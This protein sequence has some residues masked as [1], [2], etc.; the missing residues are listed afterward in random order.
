MNRG[1][2]SCE[3]PARRS[4]APENTLQR[5]ISGC[6]FFLLFYLY[7]WLVIDPRLLHHSLGL[8][9]SYHCVSYTTE[10]SFFWEC[11]SRPGGVV[12]YGA[13]FLWQFFCYGWMGALIVTA[14]AWTTSLAVDVLT[15]LADRPRGLVVRFVPAVLLAVICGHYEQ[16][17]KTVLSLLVA[18][19]CFAAYLRWSSRGGGG[20]SVALLVLTC[21]VA[22]LLAGSGGLLFPCLAA[23]FEFIHR[24]R[25]LVGLVALLCVAGV[26]LTVGAAV[27]RI[28]FGEQFWSCLLSDEQTGRPSWL[29]TG[30]YLFFLAAFV[31]ATW[32]RHWQ[33]GRASTRERR[34]KSESTMPWRMRMP[35]FLQVGESGFA[36]RLAVVCLTAGAIAWSTLDRSGRLVLQLD[37]YCQHGKWTEALD[38]AARLPTGRVRAYAHRNVLLALCRT[39]RLLDEMFHYPQVT[40]DPYYRLVVEGGNLLFYTQDSRIFL[41]LGQVNLAEKCCLE[42]MVLSGERPSILKQLAVINI[43]KDR[44]ETAKVFLNKLR[45]TLLHRKEAEAMLNRLEQD[46]RMDDDPTVGRLRLFMARKDLASIKVNWEELLVGLLDE[47]PDNRVAFDLLNA[48][49]LRNLQVDKVVENLSSLE[50][51]G[52]RRIPRHLQEAIIVQTART[53]GRLAVPKELVASETFQRA[54]LFSD[55]FRRFPDRQ[56]AARVSAEAGLGSSYFHYYA[57]G[58]SGL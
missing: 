28:P 42:A 3:L 2:E 23:I 31:G 35:R 7:V 50:R 47:K 44:P 30:L 6:V 40:G 46:P 51:C 19:V 52:Y 1:T 15:R 9:C 24:R 29:F 39:S 22:F 58:E 11:V 12:D 13:R 57:F 20:R 5:W 26:P 25:G 18:F 27:F 8:L 55:I 34:R 14:A 10:W 16:P 33:A 53:G 21:V 38:S 17:L 36:I 4:T 32:S 43:A 54:K 49:Y 37:Y 45:K 56:E 48:L 41:E